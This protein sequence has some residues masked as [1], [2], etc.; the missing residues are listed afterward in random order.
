MS[1]EVIV[2]ETLRA[3]P[4]QAEALR[5]ALLELV[6]HTLKEPGCISYEIADAQNG[7][8]IFLVLMRW[9]Q[10]ENYQSHEHSAHIAEFV[11]KYDH[12]LYGEVRESV[13]INC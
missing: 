10:V 3:M 7:D 2:V 6:P 4:G 11:K 9:K 8:D 1:K 5:K 12:V 13:W